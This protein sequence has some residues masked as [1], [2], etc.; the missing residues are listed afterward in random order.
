M[1]LRLLTRDDAEAFRDLR[2]VALQEC[3]SAFTADYEANRQRPLSH[4]AGQIQSLPDNFIVGAFEGPTL[5]GMAAF[6]R[7]EGPKLQHKGN[8]WTMYVAP[9]LRL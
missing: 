4:F 5:S 9:G 1:E 2:L 6:Y 3:P 8:I 7:S